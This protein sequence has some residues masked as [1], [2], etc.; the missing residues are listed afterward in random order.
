MFRLVSKN[1]TNNE[2]LW[3]IS[4]Q[5]YLAFT[6]NYNVHIFINEARA[7]FTHINGLMVL[8]TSEIK[9]IV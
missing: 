5:V 6:A 3:Y 1:N 9:T 4:P 8:S 7:P 2:S